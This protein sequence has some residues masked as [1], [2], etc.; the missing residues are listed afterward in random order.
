MRELPA[1]T[2]LLTVVVWESDFLPIDIRESS[3]EAGFVLKV[4][5]N[6]P[7]N[8]N[9]EDVVILTAYKKH[10]RLLM[11]HL[12]TKKQEVFT[13]DD[14][15]GIKKESGIFSCGRHDGGN[16]FLKDR[17]RLCVGFS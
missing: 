1:E 14:T 16:G 5:D 7:W 2:C 17:R 15:Q 6:F 10:G 3:L 4:H 11:K 13:V 9:E 12:C 8:C